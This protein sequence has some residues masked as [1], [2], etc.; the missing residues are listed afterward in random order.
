[1]ITV[2]KKDGAK[3]PYD[4]EKLRNSII[5]AAKDAGFD[6]DRIRQVVN[7]ITQKVTDRISGEEEVASHRLREIILRELDNIEAEIA[8]AWR[9]YEAAK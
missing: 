3:E 6:E 2:I 7:N 9:K 4:E 8:D 5:A 1:M